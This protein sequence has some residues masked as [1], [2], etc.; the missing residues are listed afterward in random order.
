[1]PWALA[2]EAARARLRWPVPP[3]QP[4]PLLVHITAVLGKLYHTR[5]GRELL[6]G[7]RE[8]SGVALKRVGPEECWA[9]DLA[10]ESLPGE[11]ISQECSS[12]SERFLRMLV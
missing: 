1:M 10:T 5:C 3:V 8:K 12:C 4:S 11:Y 6:S 7:L 9:K 2:I